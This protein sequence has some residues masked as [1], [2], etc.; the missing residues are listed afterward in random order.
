V[1]KGF[2]TENSSHKNIDFWLLTLTTLLP[3]SGGGRLI[4]VPTLKD[5]KVCLTSTRLFV[6]LMFV[7]CSFVVRLKNEQQ[8]N[9]RRT[10]NEQQCN[11]TASCSSV[12][13]NI[14]AAKIYVSFFPPIQNFFVALQ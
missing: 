4:F 14:Y 8:T 3:T 6:R 1:E 9:N 11:F 10:S 2:Q 5:T 7:C 13:T 12:G